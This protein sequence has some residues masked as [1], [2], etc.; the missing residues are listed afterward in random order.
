MM[1]RASGHRF[2]GLLV[3]LVAMPAESQDSILLPIN[4]HM[5]VKQTG[6]CQPNG[7]GLP[8]GRATHYEEMVEQGSG[9]NCLAACAFDDGCN[10]GC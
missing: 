6:Y 9:L 8:E 1:R 7:I 2:C 5:W 10:R 3:L 4:D